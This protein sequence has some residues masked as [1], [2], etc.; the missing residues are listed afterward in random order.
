[1]D[2]SWT[3]FFLLALG[4]GLKGVLVTEV[5]GYVYNGGPG[6]GLPVSG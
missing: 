3:L 4:L 2:A 6:S 5:E 1:M